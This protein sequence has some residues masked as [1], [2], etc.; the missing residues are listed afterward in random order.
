MMKKGTKKSIKQYTVSDK[1]Y[2]TIRFLLEDINLKKIRFTTRKPLS[3][4]QIFGSIGKV[5]KLFGSTDEDGSLIVTIKEKDWSTISFSGR[6]PDGN[7]VSNNLNK[8]FMFQSLPSDIELYIY[9]GKMSYFP[10][11]TLDNS[12]RPIRDVR[13]ISDQLGGKEWKPDKTGKIV[14]SVSP[15]EMEDAGIELNDKITFRISSNVYEKRSQTFFANTEK[16]DRG[17]TQKKIILEQ[18]I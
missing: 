14:P 13:I 8:G 5:K 10:M 12:N 17:R 16:Y 15:A 3:D 6:H 9:P 11:Q 1:D 2:K 4:I 7:I 18:K